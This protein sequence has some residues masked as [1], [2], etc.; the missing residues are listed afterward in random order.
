MA[1]SEAGQA[2]DKHF[3]LLSPAE[4][5]MPH[6]PYSHIAKEKAAGK[7]VLPQ[8]F[9]VLFIEGI[10]GAYHQRL[11]SAVI[12]ISRPRVSLLLLLSTVPIQGIHLTYVHCRSIH[13]APF[14]LPAHSPANILT[15]RYA[16]AP[17]HLN[18]A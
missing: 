9:A 15:M 3:V 17:I 10:S 7:D 2:V 1:G 14:A 13:K 6:Y 12:S 18:T 4:V 8:E 5:E 11:L 16:V